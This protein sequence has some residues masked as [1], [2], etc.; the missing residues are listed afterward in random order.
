MQTT[1]KAGW[2]VPEWAACAGISRSLT[3]E[4]MAAGRI[5]SV[6]IGAARI[7]TTP[8][9]AFLAHVAEATPN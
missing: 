4:L 5:A 2:R 9:A 1:D 8:P 7:I 3:Y 6:K